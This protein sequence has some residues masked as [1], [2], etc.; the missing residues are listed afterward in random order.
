MKSF[1]I[2]CLKWGDKYPVKYVN[3]L[4]RACNRNTNGQLNFHCVTEDNSGIDEDVICHPLPE[5]D[6]LGGWWWKLT[7]FDPKLYPQLPKRFLFLDLDVVILDNLGCFFSYMRHSPFV[8]LK[9]F[10]LPGIN[11]S[12]FRVDH[13]F[14]Q[15][16]WD[17]F[18]NCHIEGRPA[19]YYGYGGEVYHG[20]QN[21]IYAAFGRTCDV[22]PSE[23][24]RSYKKD[25]KAAVVQHKPKVV[26]F[27]GKPWPCECLE[28]EWVRNN[29]C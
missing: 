28:I 2:V 9:D 26:V 20:D 15:P 24:A 17:H 6:L 10:M 5:I 19:E 11:S 23:Y 4:Y 18:V 29:W 3:N 13:S 16:V 8:T 14:D 21:L 22:Y 1:D 7:L 27:H 25:G 12:I